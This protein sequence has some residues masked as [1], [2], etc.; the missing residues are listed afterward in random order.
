VKIE[1]PVACIITAKRY[2]EVVAPGESVLSTTGCRSLLESSAAL[3]F[4]P[5]QPIVQ[6]TC[7]PNS[8]D[9]SDDC[10]DE[11]APNIGDG[12]NDCPDN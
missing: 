11:D 6:L 8:G 1:G 5:T 2:A 7:E 9:D 4:P 12:N 10:A 3:S